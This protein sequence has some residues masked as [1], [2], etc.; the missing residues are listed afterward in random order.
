MN[1]AKMLA[2]INGCLKNVV[3][4]KINILATLI[5]ISLI[6]DT[7][8]ATNKY[9][10]AA[11]EEISTYLINMFYAVDYEHLI[12]DKICTYLYRI[13]SETT[14]ECFEESDEY[15]LFDDIIKLLDSSYSKRMNRLQYVLT[16]YKTFIDTHALNNNNYRIFEIEQP[17]PEENYKKMLETIPKK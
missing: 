9:R 8:F 11:K 14:I 12:Y 17:I 1:Y 13:I 10:E 6:L 15:V 2:K 7:K 3:D 4:E 5:Q 16:M